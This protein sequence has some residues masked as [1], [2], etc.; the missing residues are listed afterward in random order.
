MFY[1]LNWIQTFI[2]LSVFFILVGNA[3][4]EGRKSSDEDYEI[5]FIVLCGLCGLCGLI[6]IVVGLLVCKGRKMTCKTKILSY[7]L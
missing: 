1:C 6:G 3:F 4:Q 5:P 7:L 2:Q